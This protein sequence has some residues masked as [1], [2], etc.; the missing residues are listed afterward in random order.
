MHRAAR[1]EPST[2]SFPAEPTPRPEPPPHP[3]AALT[4]V[5][6]RDRQV[7]QLTPEELGDIMAMAAAAG[8]DG[9]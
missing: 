4:R 3:L 6:R 8:G 5:A 1:F 7:V 2:D 9:A